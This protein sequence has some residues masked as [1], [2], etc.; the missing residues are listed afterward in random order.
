LSS[1]ALCQFWNA[2]VVRHIAQKLLAKKCSGKNSSI[3]REPI[4]CSGR[5]SRWPSASR[6]RLSRAQVAGVE[7]LVPGAD[8]PGSGLGVPLRVERPDLVLDRPVRVGE[9]RDGIQQVPQAAV[10]LL[11]E[12]PPATR[13]VPGTGTAGAIERTAG[14]P[15][16]LKDLDARTVEPGVADQE[17]R[18]G[19]RRRCPRRP[20]RPCASSDRVMGVFSV[21]MFQPPCRVL[22][23]CS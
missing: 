8:Q 12:H 3:R 16:L 4:A 21:M 20:G 7:D 18:R 5:A 10:R 2:N 11:L 9:R 1:I 14:H 17:H 23:R 6:S 22:M 15:K 13:D 19:E